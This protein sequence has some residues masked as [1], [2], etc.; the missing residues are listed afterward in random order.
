MNTKTSGKT[1]AGG[2]SKIQLLK[3]W[4]LGTNL[5]MTRPCFAASVFMVIS[6]RMRKWNFF[7]AWM[8]RKETQVRPWVKN[9]EHGC[10]S[11]FVFST[12]G[13]LGPMAITVYKRLASIYTDKLL[14]KLTYSGRHVCIDAFLSPYPVHYICCLQGSH[15][16]V[17]RFFSFCWPVILFYFALT[18]ST[19]SISFI[20]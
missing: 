18:N 8:N 10:F 12:G 17:C 6:V 9:I 3:E 7:Q 11:S 14:K 5:M 2:E 20:T 4:K 16:P 13:G 15:S 19:C 1:G